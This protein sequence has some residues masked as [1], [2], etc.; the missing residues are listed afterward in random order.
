MKALSRLLVTDH[1]TRDKENNT[2]KEVHKKTRWWLGIKVFEKDYDADTTI[3]D[4]RKS[5]GFK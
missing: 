1:H 3:L 4:T 2:I 5:T